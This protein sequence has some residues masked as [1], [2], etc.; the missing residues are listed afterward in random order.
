MKT[1][2]REARAIER[3]EIARREGARQESAWSWFSL[4]RLW[5]FPRPPAAAA[6]QA[7]KKV[8]VSPKTQ[9]DRA[10]MTDVS[11]PEANEA[12]QRRQG[13]QSRGEEVKQRAVSTESPP[14][15]AQPPPQPAGAKAVAQGG[16]LSAV[17]KEPQQDAQPPG[18]KN[19]GI[20]KLPMVS[21]SHWI[22]AGTKEEIPVASVA[23]EQVE[24][25]VPARESA[26]DPAAMEEGLQ[27]ARTLAAGGK[28][29]DALLLVSGLIDG[30]P[31]H[32]DAYLERAV[33]YLRQ[34]QY[35]RAAEDYRRVISCRGS[36]MEAYYGLGT[37]CEQWAETLFS[38]GKEK[39][40]YDRYRDAIAAYKE[41]LWR[42]PGYAPAFYSLGC[43][44][45]RLGKT[46]DAAYYFKKTV[47]T[48]DAE[49]DIARRAR[50]NISLMGE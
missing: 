4:P 42:A 22:G 39:E 26:N 15:V 47:E 10:L 14:V 41:V 6:L 33:I 50:Y 48:A 44:Y 1:L 17:E 32:P 18:S 29:E 35:D 27:E 5:P 24:E 2:M 23:G 45:S 16:E 36:D 19:G 25:L 43:V 28:T 8:A 46:Q 31:E 34:K 12:Q 21:M 38:R 30:N 7:P 40:A 20:L 9:A 37:V 11:S 13:S 3:E 49:S